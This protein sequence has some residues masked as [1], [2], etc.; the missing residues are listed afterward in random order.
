MFSSATPVPEPEPLTM[1]VGA[2]IL[3]MATKLKKKA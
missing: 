3:G 2:G 1:L